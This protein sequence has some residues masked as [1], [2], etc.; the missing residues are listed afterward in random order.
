MVSVLWGDKAINRVAVF[1]D[2]E[3]N[4]ELLADAPHRGSPV[5]EQCCVL[6]KHSRRSTRVKLGAED[7][8]QPEP[9]GSARV[10]PVPHAERARD[11]AG[12]TDWKHR[13]GFYFERRKDPVPQRHESAHPGILENDRLLEI[14][15][16]L[17]TDIRGECL[18]PLVQ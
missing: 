17:V 18:G 11:L 3:I 10:V 14:K 6:N 4:P 13:L 15:I 5:I 2:G 7:M 9:H 1:F 8:V 16:E 12:M